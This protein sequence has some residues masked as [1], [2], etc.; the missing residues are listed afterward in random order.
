MFIVF[1][2]LVILYAI[3]QLMKM[4]FFWNIYKV[5]FTKFAFMKKLNKYWG[6]FSNSEE[7]NEFREKE[8]RKQ[9]STLRN[10]FV[11]A[12]IFNPVFIFSDYYFHSK[13]ILLGYLIVQRV[14]FEIATFGLLFYFR[15][16]RNLKQYETCITAWMVYISIVVIYINS[17]RPTEY[18][19]YLIIDVI[20]TFAAY[21][22]PALKLKLQTAIAVS[23]SLIEFVILNFFKEIP[24]HTT[25]LP[26]IASFLLANSFGYLFSRRNQLLQ[27]SQYDLLNTETKLKLEL[28]KLNGDKDK[29]FS[30]I[31]HDLKN[32]FNSILNNSELLL[33]Q[34]KELSKDEILTSLTSLN[35]AAN[36]FQELLG[37]L[38][39]WAK[40]QLDKFQLN[41]ENV[42][43]SEII[44]KIFSVFEQ[45]VLEKGIILKS[46]IN[47]NLEVVVD[48]NIV[49]SIIR[50]LLSNAI[51]FTSSGG[52]IV[53]DAAIVDNNVEIV[54]SDSG[55]GM[56]KKSVDN[57]FSTYNED[58]SSLGTENEVGTGLGLYICRELVALHGGSLKVTSE[59]GKG[60]LFKVILPQ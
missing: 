60:S 31:A 47:N 43:L 10:I 3:I 32:P 29:I 56:S 42:R 12:L 35:N 24:Q 26:Y 4:L 37:G 51:K 40:I 6:V 38:L 15:K 17:V 16:P 58:I 55:V 33:S 21:Q 41:R 39:E 30:I 34:Y 8:F 46:N 18:I 28:E 57:L 13:Q 23:F 59:Q 22:V 2:K 36:K 48:E 1:Q 19:G 53:I 20:M 25:F 49:S 11:L 54:V 45:R 9:A 27:R 44:K 50:N 14:F 5:I 7:E 52:K